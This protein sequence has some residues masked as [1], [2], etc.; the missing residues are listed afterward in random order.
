MSTEFAGFEPFS[1]SGETKLLASMAYRMPLYRDFDTKIGP[2]YFDSLYLQFF[3]TAG[4]IWSF[5]PRPLESTETGDLSIVNDAPTGNIR[6]LPLVG[7]FD[8][9]QSDKLEGQDLIGGDDESS[10]SDIP[11]EGLG[12]SYGK[13]NP[14]AF[15]RA[16]PVAYKNGNRLLTDVGAELRVRAYA[17]N[18]NPWFSFFRMSYGIQDTTGVGDQNGDRI[19]SDLPPNDDPVG[20]IEKAGFRYYLGIGTGW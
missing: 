7:L 10:Y 2:F 17:Y 13:K 11:I 18:Y 3:G 14:S 19:F 12:G 1:V 16:F 20:E 6:E 8:S 9:S 5:R 15:D 4:N